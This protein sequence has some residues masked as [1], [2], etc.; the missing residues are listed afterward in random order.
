M[1]RKSFTVKVTIF[2]VLAVFAVSII[3][4]QLAIN[5]YKSDIAELED[6]SQSL[7]IGIEELQDK[8]KKPVDDEYA[9]KLAKEKLGYRMPVEIIFYNDLAE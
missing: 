5:G 8:L 9:V 1:K 6:K 3:K 4:L 2:I 7:R